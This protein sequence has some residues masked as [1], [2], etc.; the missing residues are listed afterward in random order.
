LTLSAPREAPSTPSTPPLLSVTGAP[1]EAL[2]RTA[3][4]LLALGA[5]GSVVLVGWRRRTHNA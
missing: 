3:L 1:L 2:M 5:V 4:A